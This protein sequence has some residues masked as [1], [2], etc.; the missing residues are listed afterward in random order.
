MSSV[1]YLFA[2]VL[3]VLIYVIVKRLRNRKL[4]RHKI[5]DR[6]TSKLSNIL[7]D[8]DR[9]VKGAK[10]P[11][12]PKSPQFDEPVLSPTKILKDF[13]IAAIVSKVDRPA[14]LIDKHQTL[15]ISSKDA[16]F[17]SPLLNEKLPL[18]KTIFCSVGRIDMITPYKILIL[19]YHQYTHIGTGII[20]VL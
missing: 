6:F 2:C 18:M 5:I 19:T 13:D 12:T 20:Y 8:Y 1:L 10:T 15:E 7:Q 17:V 4:A 9:A 14:F 16:S 3:L 11:F